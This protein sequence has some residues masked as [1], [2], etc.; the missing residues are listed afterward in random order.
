[1]NGTKEGMITTKKGMIKVKYHRHVELIDI[2]DAVKILLDCNLKI[3][4]ITF[5]SKYN[6][7]KIKYFEYM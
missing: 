3:N 6:M 1:M 2:P 4:K 7:W 5:D